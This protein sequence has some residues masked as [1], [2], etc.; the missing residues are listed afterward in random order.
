MS[1]G[2]GSSWRGC[3]WRPRPCLEFLKAAW[4][5]AQATRRRRPELARQEA[6]WI[7]AGFAGWLLAARSL[8][9]SPSARARARGL[10]W[11]AGCGLMLDWHLGMLE[12]PEGRPVRLGAADALTLA[13]AWLAP[14]VAAQPEPM[15]L[16]VGGLT[17]V[18]D[19]RIARVTR[20]TR[21]G[22]DLEGLAD[23]CFSWAALRGAVRAGGLSPRPAALE[24]AR[25]LAGTAHASA[26]YFVAGRAPN[27]AVRRGGRSAV[28]LRLGGLVAGGLGR[29]ALA[30]RLVLTGTVMAIDLE[31]RRSQDTR[32]PAGPTR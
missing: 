14:A 31:L 7:L 20:C 9:A 13:R 10:L 32:A 17:D 16:L 3:G 11:W 27:P 4:I 22:R 18:A 2:P 30:D 24:Q 21:F 1:A 28:P 19:G 5:K 23:A 8:P 29:R 6:A 15:L 26:A 12:T 25:L